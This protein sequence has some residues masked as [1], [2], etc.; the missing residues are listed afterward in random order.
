MTDVPYAPGAVLEDVALFPLP[1]VVLFPG[2]LMPLHVFEPRYRAMTRDVVAS[3]RRVCIVQIPEDHSLDGYGQPGVATIAGVGEVVKCDALP[4]GR[5]NVLVEG[6]ARA[7]LDELPFRRPYRKAQLTILPCEGTAPDPALV[8]AL[9][10][11]ATRVAGIVRQCHPAFRFC[12]P[13][14]EDA[15]QL[16]DACAHYLVLDGSERQRLLETL[17]VGERLERCLEFLVAQ[18]TLLGGCGETMH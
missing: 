5:F 6:K 17:D 10:S 9:V 8:R 16:A 18:Q 12:L 14:T 15:G 4:D 1:Q 11:T 13:E 7:R 3:T 2:A